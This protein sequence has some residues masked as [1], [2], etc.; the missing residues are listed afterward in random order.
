MRPTR[1]RMSARGRPTGRRLLLA[2]C[3]T[4]GF[5]DDLGSGISD[6]ANHVH[7]GKESYVGRC[8]DDM[9]DWTVWYTWQGAEGAKK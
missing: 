1:V 5:V 8:E 3:V 7:A 9:A 4:V 6:V 2:C